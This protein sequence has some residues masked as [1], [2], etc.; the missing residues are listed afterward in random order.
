MNNKKTPKVLMNWAALP[1]KAVMTRALTITC[2]ACLVANLWGQDTA[3]EPKVAPVPPLPTFATEDPAVYGKQIAEYWDLINQGWKDELSS[4][5]MIL[6][7]A[8]GDVVE[9]RLSRRVLEE[10]KKGDKSL[11]RFTSPAEVKGVAA[12]THEHT[13]KNDDQWLYLPSRKRVS[14][15]SGAN[16]TA[17]FQGS[18]FTYEDLANTD[19]VKYDWKYLGIA[20]LKSDGEEIDCYRL[21]ARPNYRD[22]GYSRL[23]VWI[24]K[25]RWQQEKIMFY[26]K[27]GQLLKSLVNSE[28]KEFHGRF[29][30]PRKIS[31]E[32]H[33]SKKK[34]VLQIRKQFVNLAFY[35]SKRTGK[36][37]KNLT[38]ANFTTRVLERN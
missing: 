11:L 29:W 36:A 12:L 33:Q 6:T 5:T 18:E 32:N 7:D 21:E 22:T 24:S 19:V 31:I 16:K 2:T 26:D 15:I 27:A 25:G 38:D 14:R 20:K 9:R 35:K 1:S 17:S 28:F 10:S 13:G 4:S 8:R 37:R 34:T 3:K 30:R 23:I